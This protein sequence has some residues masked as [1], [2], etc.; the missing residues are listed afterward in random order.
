MSVKPCVFEAEILSQEKVGSFFRLRFSAPK[1]LSKA[2]PGQFVS[3]R[4]AQGLDPLL[5]R[6]YS[7]A[8]VF[9]RGRHVVLEVL[10][11]VH[12][13]GS[14]LLSRKKKGEK[15]NV[16]GPLGS[17]FPRLQE[18]TPAYLVAGGIGVAP[19]VFLAEVLH[20]RKVPFHVFFGARTKRDLVDVEVF[21]KLEAP[22]S[23]A[24]DDGTAG[25]RGRVTQ[26][27]EKL[28]RR[29]PPSPKARVY[30][31]G[32]RPMFRALGDLCSAFGVCAYFAW[33]EAMAC[34]L[35]ICLT[36]V[37]PLKQK[38]ETKWVR[39]CMEGPVVEASRID[40]KALGGKS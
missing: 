28:W 26:A 19:L 2:L 39:T 18:K 10:Y 36:C 3:L 24:T 29:N 12:R 8:R 11:T 33:E 30:A 17:P 15:L 23:L 20:R 32:P 25:E 9:A 5:R 22:L 14:F 40:W 37:C 13:R 27:L 21:R 7:I 35:G 38:E 1:S 6:P 31:C 4:A 34:G 16:L